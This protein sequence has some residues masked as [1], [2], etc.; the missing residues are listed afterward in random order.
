MKDTFAEG[1]GS[2]YTKWFFFCKLLDNKNSGFA[3]HTISVAM[4][5]LCYCGMKAGIDRH[6]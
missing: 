2:E 5:Q 4:T 6:M 1:C 3:G